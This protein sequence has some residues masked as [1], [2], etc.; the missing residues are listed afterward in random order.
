MDAV[1][2]SYESQARSEALMG[3]PSAY[4]DPGSIDH[5]RH[6]RMQSLIKGLVLALPTARWMTVG[7]GRYGSDAAYLKSI[8]ADVLATSLTDE[9]LKIASE[10]GFIGRYQIENAEQLS[11][12]DGAFDFVF[13]KESYHHF[14]RPPIALYEML[15]AARVGAVLIEPL[16]NPRLLDTVKRGI[17]RLLRGDTEFNFEPSG[18]FLY[19]I[20]VHELGQLMCAMGNHTIALRGINDFFHPRL[21][22]ERAGGRAW[23][24]LLTRLGV[25]LQDVL[26]RLG[27]LGYGLCCVVAFNGTP[28]TAL[29]N[30]LR[31]EGFQIIDLP[32]NPYAP[33]PSGPN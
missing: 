2:H 21:S 14:P 3:M 5:W 28:S 9:R 11:C 1:K 16:H 32:R 6:L 19:R 24:F 4:T 27:L 13:C 18:N 22:R 17:K 15:R 20:N 10:Q 7:D 26:A 25:A 29:L 12:A 8:G 33:T 31:R 30:A 23:P